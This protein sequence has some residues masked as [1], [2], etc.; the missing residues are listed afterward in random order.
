MGGF[1]L[2][3]D[4]LPCDTMLA[5]RDVSLAANIQHLLMSLQWGTHECELF[6]RQRESVSAG[7]CVL[8]VDV[9]VVVF[10]YYH[11]DDHLML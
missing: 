6:I 3:Y 10:Y 4:V 7:V 9:V 5:M 1:C 2:G 8:L 11:S